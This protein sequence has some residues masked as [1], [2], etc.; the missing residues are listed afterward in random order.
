MRLEGYYPGEYRYEGFETEEE[1]L[2][3]KPDWDN[4]LEKSKIPE[5][6]I[7]K[8]RWMKFFAEDCPENLVKLLT[9]KTKWSKDLVNFVEEKLGLEEEPE[10]LKLLSTIGGP[11]DEKGID[12]F[13]ILKDPK[14][15]KPIFLSIDLSKHTSKVDWKIDEKKPSEWGLRKP[16]AD[17]IINLDEFPSHRHNLKKY[18]Q[19]MD[20]E[21]QKIA[22]KIKVKIRP[23]IH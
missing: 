7:S 1:C 23:T 14:T 18:I 8:E 12:C 22:E 2:G 17:H 16:K 21:S 13:F 9:P 10:A 3:P 19:K 4:I 6:D 11:L 15:K 5:T 20:E